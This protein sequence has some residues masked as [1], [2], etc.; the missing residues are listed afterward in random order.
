LPL[1]LPPSLTHLDLS[2]NC[3]SVLDPPSLSALVNLQVLRINSNCLRSVPES[4]FDALPRL[5]SVELANNLW[6]CECEILVVLTHRLPLHPLCG[7]RA[8]CDG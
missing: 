3:I 5:R 8:G 2:A 7:K 6:V 1:D 4:A